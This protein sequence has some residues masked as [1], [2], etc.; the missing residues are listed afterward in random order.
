[1]SVAHMT[2]SAQPSKFFPF[3]SMGK[4]KHS[5]HPLHGNRMTNQKA[6]YKYTSLCQAK[7]VTVGF[8]ISK[9]IEVMHRISGRS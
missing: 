7:C 3:M 2:W 5:E 4:K 1:M 8:D 6:E 9:T